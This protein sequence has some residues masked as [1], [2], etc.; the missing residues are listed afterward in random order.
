MNLCCG[1]VGLPNVGKSTLFNRLGHKG[2]AKA[3]NYP[4]CTIDPNMGV[5]TVPDLRLRQISDCFQPQKTLP[6]QVEFVDIAGLVQGASEGEGLGNQFLDNIRQT[7]AILHVVRC[8]ENREVTHVHGQVNPLH[9][10]EVIETELLLS[11][12]QRVEKRIQ[13]I[14]KQAKQQKDLKQELE[15]L[16]KVQAQLHVAKPLRLLSWNE[17]E[18]TLIKGFQLL[19]QKPVLYLCNMDQAQWQK[20]QKGEKIESVAA[21]ADHAKKNQCEYLP[22]CVEEKGSNQEEAEKAEETE[23]A[24]ENLPQETSHNKESVLHPLIQK[25]YTLLQLQTFF[26]AGK[27]EVRAWAFL[28]GTKAPQAAGTIHSDF[29]KGFICAEI[30]PCTK[31]LEL[32]S[33]VQVRKKGF[34]RR[35]GKNYIV[36]DGDVV[37]FR[38]NV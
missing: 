1:I 28:K 10:I 33:E 12:L 8:F 24:N 18:Q 36:Q 34:C 29:E 22:L 5:V 16:E 23:E 6:S 7:Q 14:E 21:I 27:K 20:L 2:V 11:D 4:F 38:F 3:A 37:L 31:L 32:K 26:T 13:K 30:Y 25:T 35:E 15:A 9:D 19:S 17:E